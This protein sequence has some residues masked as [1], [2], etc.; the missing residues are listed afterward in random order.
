MNSL[1]AQLR[2]LREAHRH[3]VAPL[4]LDVVSHSMAHPPSTGSKAL[5]S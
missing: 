3:S 4:G 2:Q 5:L 1:T